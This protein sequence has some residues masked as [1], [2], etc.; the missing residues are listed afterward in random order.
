MVWFSSL[1]IEFYFSPVGLVV[2]AKLYESDLAC[3][4]VSRFVCTLLLSV[5]P[6]VLVSAR[7]LGGRRDGIVIGLVPC[8]T[9]SIYGWWLV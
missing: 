4:M 7:V 1:P 5:S 9:Q 2:L 6:C 3:T 8:K